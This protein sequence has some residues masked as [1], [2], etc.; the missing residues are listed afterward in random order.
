MH[1]GRIRKHS[2]KN[3]R[4]RKYGGRTGELVGGSETTM[5]RAGSRTGASGSWW[6]REHVKK[7]R[8][9]GT[10][11]V[12]EQGGRITQQNRIFRIQKQGGTIVDK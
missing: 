7:I 6:D 2:G 10:Q 12:R 1:Y 11:D 3:S 4:C 5:G 8:E 9:H